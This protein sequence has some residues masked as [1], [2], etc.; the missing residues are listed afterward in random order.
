VLKRVLVGTMIGKRK[1]KAQQSEQAQWDQLT[2]STPSRVLAY[3]RPRC[4]GLVFLFVLLGCS[5]PPRPHGVAAGA[6]WVESAKTGYWER[7][8]VTDTKAVHCTIWNAGGMVLMDEPYLPLD[9]GPP[10]SA[11]D[12]RLRKTAAGYGVRLANGRILAPQSQFQRMKAL[13]G[14]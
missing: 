1:K 7:C 10:P 11:K 5:D 9:G 8:E 6:T 2:Q 3:F 14:P 4:L 13:Y 12:L